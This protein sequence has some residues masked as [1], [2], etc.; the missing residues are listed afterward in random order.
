[1]QCDTAHIENCTIPDDYWDDRNGSTEMWMNRF[2]FDV[3]RESEPAQ[4]VTI[5]NCRFAQYWAQQF[6]AQTVTVE[7]VTAQAESWCISKAKNVRLTHFINPESKF[8]SSHTE[9]GIYLHDCDS[10]A[11]SIE[12][13]ELAFVLAYERRY[14]AVSKLKSITVVDSSIDYLIGDEVITESLSWKNS[15]KYETHYDVI[16]PTGKWIRF[17]ACSVTLERLNHADTINT[18]CYARLFRSVMEARP[19]YTD[20]KNVKAE[21][22]Y[23]G[24]ADGSNDSYNNTAYTLGGHSVSYP[25]LCCRLDEEKDFKTQ[26][27]QNLFKIETKSLT[28]L[29]GDSITVKGWYSYRDY[30][31]NNASYE[32]VEEFRYRTSQYNR[33]YISPN[34]N[35]YIR[36]EKTENS[37]V[38]LS[39]SVWRKWIRVITNSVTLHGRSMDDYTPMPG[40]PQF[41]D[42]SEAHP[43]GIVELYGYQNVTLKGKFFFGLT[44]ARYGNGPRD[45]LPAFVAVGANIQTDGIA[46][47]HNSL[48]VLTGT[49]FDTLRNNTYPCTVAVKK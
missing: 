30:W 38:T 23:C 7:R 11:V 34:C 5:K 46:R 47:F 45:F 33:S 14:N 16:V 15:R 39:T 24:Y 19:V 32:N 41:N 3:N 13:S 27:T 49:V 42:P 12:D 48:N 36:N 22:I 20:I 35:C 6:T 21:R 1:M 18:L 4:S 40:D 10:A 44:G 26:G 25:T 29:S 9:Q 31:D 28:V 17:P 37:T 8:A 2:I 43:S